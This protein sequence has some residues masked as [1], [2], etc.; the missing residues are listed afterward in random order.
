AE[1]GIRDFHVTGVQTCALPI[2]VDHGHLGAL[3][4]EEEEHRLVVEAVARGRVAD[5][6]RAFDLVAL[7]DAERLLF[8]PRELAPRGL[9]DFAHPGVARALDEEADEEALEA[10]VARAAAE[11]TVE[12]LPELARLAEAR[13]DR[14]RVG[15]G[16]R[17]RLLTAAD[18]L[19]R[20][21][22][23]VEVAVATD[24]VDGPG[25]LD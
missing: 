19:R 6:E 1:D 14:A 25:G 17:V 21:A 23:P 8:V 9:E 15:V 3:L 12:E 4:A 16:A 10:V 22:E 20:G 5:R 18:P 2:F 24:R 7:G 13:V 11:R